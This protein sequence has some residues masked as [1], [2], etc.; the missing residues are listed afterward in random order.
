MDFFDTFAMSMVGAGRLHIFTCV[1]N[2]H[3]F[4][5]FIFLVKE[6]EKK[7]KWKKK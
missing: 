4:S 7:K 3:I 1:E 5:G 6:P 2:V